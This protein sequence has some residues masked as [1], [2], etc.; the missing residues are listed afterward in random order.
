MT[1]SCSMRRCRWQRMGW[2]G[3]Q[4]LQRQ[5][6]IFTHWKIEVMIMKAQNI[7]GFIAFEF[8][9]MRGI[10]KRGQVQ[11]MPPL[12]I[13]SNPTSI[14]EPDVTLLTT[15]NYLFFPSFFQLSGLFL[16]TKAKKAKR[17]TFYHLARYNLDAFD[18]L[19]KTI[20]FSKSR[21]TK[22]LGQ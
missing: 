16:H 21:N 7:I 14:H 20:S 4:H 3:S 10:P 2:T 22:N 19:S 9:N 5:Q 1:F 13:R 12:Q 6:N 15:H 11:V 8:G 18:N 17:N